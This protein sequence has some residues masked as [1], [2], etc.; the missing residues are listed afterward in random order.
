[1]CATGFLRHD[2]RR[3]TIHLHREIGLSLGGIDLRV[4]CRVDD[5]VGMRTSNS[6][7][8][9]VF[10]D[11]VKYGP[12][13]RNDIAQW[14]QGAPQLP[15]DLAGGAYEQDLDANLRRIRSSHR[16]KHDASQGS[17]VLR[18]NCRRDPKRDPAPK[19]GLS[20]DGEGGRNHIFLFE[21]L[22]GTLRALMEILGLLVSPRR[23][24][25]RADSNH[26]EST[27]QMMRVF[28][29][30][31]AIAATLRVLELDHG[32]PAPQH[33]TMTLTSVDSE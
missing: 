14:C 19:R 25:Q 8:N 10:I 15:A 16:F 6:S 18:K 27:D 33:L 4:S 23:Q 1:M 9:R 5:E 17:S 31:S 7:T 30:A 3:M 20:V 26:R 24:R 2:S 12:V 21:R 22:Y 29:F 13:G 11:K 32:Q 28:L